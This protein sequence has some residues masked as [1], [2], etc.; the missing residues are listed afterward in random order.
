MNQ[1]KC[2]ACRD[3]FENLEDFNDHSCVSGQSPNMASDK[4]MYCN[5]CQMYVKPTLWYGEKVCPYHQRTMQTEDGVVFM[6]D[7]FNQDGE[8]W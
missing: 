8:E 1:I 3:I 2:P 5:S 6:Y 4:T 7:E